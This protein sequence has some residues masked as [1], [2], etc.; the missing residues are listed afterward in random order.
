MEAARRLM[1]RALVAVGFIVGALVALVGVELVLLSRREYLPSDPGYVVDMRVEPRGSAS[2]EL[3]RLAVLGDS[4]VAGVGSPTEAESLPVLIAQRV[5][6]ATGRPVEVTGFGVP[7][8]RTATLTADQLPRVGGGYDVLVLVIGS[9]DATHATFWPDLRRQTAEMLARASALGAPVVM[10]GTPRFSGTE[11]IPQPLRTM[12]DRYSGV[13]RNEQRAAASEAA[14]VRF[15]D[16]A[17]EA[18]PRFTGVP[19]AT[20]TDGFHP[21]PIGYGFWADALAPAVVDVLSD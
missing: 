5:A 2:G 11:I 7:G 9:N 14:G 18:S 19:E 6:D 15:V 1:R 13:L 20:S 3:V 17:T 21:S 16:L 8:A 12:L 10:A 4:T